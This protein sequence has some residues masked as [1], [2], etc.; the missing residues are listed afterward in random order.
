MRAK[1][2]NITEPNFGVRSFCDRYNVSGI[3][4]LN[5]WTGKNLYAGYWEKEMARMESYNKRLIY[6]AFKIP[7]PID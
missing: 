1:D 6:A 4:A 3:A 7:P 2:E 5:I